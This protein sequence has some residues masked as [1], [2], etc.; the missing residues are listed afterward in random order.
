VVRLPAFGNQ[1]SA[2]SI[3]NHFAGSQIRFN[4]Q[5]AVSIPHGLR[6]LPP[7][8]TKIRI[9]LTQLADEFLRYV[10][11]ISPLVQFFQEIATLNHH[12][13]FPARGSRVVQS[14]QHFA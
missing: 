1:G 2:R 13:R 3:E 10:E 12:L 11:S 9:P 7:L 5:T 14:L 8:S 6:L 4:F